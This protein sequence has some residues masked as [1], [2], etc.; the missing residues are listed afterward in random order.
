MS[1]S[2]HRLVVMSQ[3]HLMKQ[4]LSVALSA[5]WS[6]IKE[7]FALL[8]PK[9]IL[10]C[11]ENISAPWPIFEIL[12]VGMIELHMFSASK[13]SSLCICITNFWFWW[14]MFLDLKCLFNLYVLCLFF[15][16]FWSLSS[17]V[18]SDHPFNSLSGS[19]KNRCFELVE[20]EPPNCRCDNLCKTYDTCCSDF[21]EHC[22]KTGK[23]YLQIF[24]FQL[25]DTQWGP[26][27]ESLWCKMNW[28][29]FK[30]CTILHYRSIMK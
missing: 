21:D 12:Q 9:S 13:Q 2:S 27:S 26:K 23:S 14:C 3:E 10:R 19:C 11:A 17:Q 8:Y 4:P 18:L 30:F 7:I 5:W 20:A 1:V 28:N 15:F 16:L 29:N 25:G 6:K 22:L 24:S